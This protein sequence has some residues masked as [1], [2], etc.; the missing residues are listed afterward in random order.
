MVFTGFN[1]GHMKKWERINHI[2]HCLELISDLRTNYKMD[3]GG[4]NMLSGAESYLDRL[5]ALEETDDE[6]LGLKDE[7]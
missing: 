1:R 7:N 4:F 5:Q 3:F 2:K 6:A